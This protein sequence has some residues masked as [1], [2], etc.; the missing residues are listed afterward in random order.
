MEPKNLIFIM[1]DEHNSNFLGVAGNKYIKTPNLDSLAR[2]GVLF[3][4]AYTPSPLCVPARAAMATGKHVHNISYWD[5]AHAYDGK[6]KGWAHELRDKNYNVTSIGKLHYKNWDI[7]TGF[8]ETIEPMHLKDGL[9]DLFGL[10]REEMPPK[11]AC[12]RLSE[13]LGRGDCEYLEYD[14]TITKKACSW[15]D[16]IVKNPTE[17]PWVLF[18]SYVSP[19]YPLIAPPE[20]YDLYDD[21]DL[22]MPEYVDKNSDKLHSWIK[23][24]RKGWPYDD[25]MDDD[26]R[27]V[28]IQAYYGMCSFMD[29]NVGKVL[30]KLKNLG[31]YEDTMKIY[32]SD[33]GE[34]LGN[35]GLWGKMTMYQDAS[36][37]P[38]IIA[39]PEINGNEICETPTTLL[40]IYPTIFDCLDIN[41]NN[42]KSNLPGKSLIEIS[43]ND[44]DNKRWVLSEY[45]G[46]GSVGGAYM[47]REGDYKYIYYVEHRCELYNIKNDPDEHN[48]I[49]LNEENKALV[50]EYDSRLRS[51]LNPE[52]V[53]LRARA[54]QRAMLDSVGG[55]DFVLNR[56]S[57]AGTP[58][59]S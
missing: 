16:N 39:G 37:I 26:K 48:N 50:E 57:Y 25:Y 7:D 30:G 18:I 34:C 41:L 58:V 53:D 46:A 23:G 51:I 31:L 47:L 38:M 20:F 17:K 32:A 44:Y 2:D 22:P 40:D 42:E 59:G 12:K 24:I 35:R 54:D 21:I 6:I 15:L 4:N 55:L 13:E 5:G 56:G 45:H 36:S 14:R 9:G 29:S 3:N 43:Q 19:H 8:T 33:H 52:E 10:L 28:A 1:A 27:K 49:A 11:L